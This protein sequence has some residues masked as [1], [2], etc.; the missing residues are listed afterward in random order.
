MHNRWWCHIYI[1]H[2]TLAYNASRRN[3]KG[4]NTRDNS[5]GHDSWTYLDITPKICEMW[6]YILKLSWWLCRKV[7]GLPEDAMKKEKKQRDGMEISSMLL[8]TRVTWSNTRDTLWP[9]NY[10]CKNRHCTIFIKHFIKTLYHWHVSK[11]FILSIQVASKKAVHVSELIYDV[12]EPVRGLFHLNLYQ[13]LG[14]WFAKIFDKKGGGVIG[15]I[16]IGG[17]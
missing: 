17:G 7:N 4:G 11:P 5:F 10:K 2:Y 15:E 1:K 9:D 16:K 8:V 3:Q 14:L 13:G 6:E 12:W